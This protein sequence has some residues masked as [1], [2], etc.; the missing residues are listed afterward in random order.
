M[1]SDDNIRKKLNIIWGKHNIHTL[2]QRLE[3]G[4]QKNMCLLVQN[5]KSSILNNGF[6]SILNDIVGCNAFPFMKTLKNVYPYWV[7]KLVTNAMDQAMR[8][9]MGETQPNA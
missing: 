9:K 1:V 8:N 3:R 4:L 5:M 7:Y 6:E 2:I